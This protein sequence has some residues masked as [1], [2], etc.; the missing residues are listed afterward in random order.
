MGQRLHAHP[1]HTSVVVAI[2]AFIVLG[3]TALAAPPAGSDTR[4]RVGLPPHSYV[5]FQVGHHPPEHQDFG[6]FGPG[7]WHEVKD[8]GL[9][10]THKGKRTDLRVGH[11]RI[12]NPHPFSIWV[13]CP[14]HS[15]AR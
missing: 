2:L 6:Y 1:T 7:W 4:F 3:G 9:Y 12:T 14:K 5:S 15:A 11:H 8:C 10:A 13:K